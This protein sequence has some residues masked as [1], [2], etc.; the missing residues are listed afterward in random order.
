[1][2]Q[3]NNFNA[4]ILSEAFSQP[5]RLLIVDDDP[6]MRSCIRHKLGGFGLEIIERG[7]GCG[8]IEALET[9]EFDLVLLDIGLPDIS[10]LEVIEWISLN[11][12]QTSVIFV[13]A[14]DDIDS[15]ILA[16]RMGAVEYVRKTEDL[17]E[18][19]HKVSNALYRRRLEHKNSIMTA[20]LEHSEKLHRFLVE[21]SPDLI[22]TLDDNARFT[23]INK[24]FES[25]LGYSHDELIGSQY[26]TIVHEDDVEKALYAFSERRVDGRATSNLEVRLKCKNDGY[27]HFENNQIVSMLSATA[28]Y[29]D[30]HGDASLAQKQYLGTYGVAHNIT[31]RKIAEETIAYQAF[32]DQ[33]TVLPN[34]RLFKD[35]LEMAIIHARRSG[36]MVGVMFIDLDRFKLVN[37][38]Y[39]HAAGDELLKNVAFRLRLCMRA[40]DTL[41]R[42]G[43][44]EFTALLPDIMKSEDAT[45]VAEKIIC[46]LNVPFI[47]AGQ[48]M[49]IT[50]SIGIA[51]LPGDGEN[52]DTLLKN[53]DIAMY[54]VKEGGKNDFKYFIPSMNA[55][56]RERITLENDLRQAIRRNE[57]E[58]NYQPQFSVSK[59]TI[60]G[61]E[62]LIRW[63]HPTKGLL[64]PSSFIDLAEEIG[65]ISSITDWVLDAACKQLSLWRTGGFETLRMSVN[66]SPQEFERENIVARILPHVINYN[67][68][69]DSLEIEITENIMMRDAS[70]VIA[71]IRTLRSHGIRVVI[72]DFGTCYSSLNYLRLFPV[73]TIKID[74]SFVRDLFSEHSTVPIIQAITGIAHGYGLNLLAEGVESI[75]QSKALE[76]IGCDEMQGFYYSVPL[77][78]DETE[79]LLCSVSNGTSHLFPIPA[80]STNPVPAATSEFLQILPDNHSQLLLGRFRND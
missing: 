77:P 9:G 57:F 47:V 35:R 37:D 11:N 14:N 53:A 25:L 59:K 20:R 54:K 6:H 3:L 33:L 24:R 58:L 30:N 73:S 34:Q 70:S 51:V 22:Y 72:D 4:D 5:Q 43:G 67:L 40:G 71:K 26:S 45:I 36:N 50:A 66:V 80:H 65:L 2:I 42:N 68:P 16:L 76:E 79:R 41:A 7:S 28:I 60:V 46:E 78:S 29:T 75:E 21:N 1:V 19:K 64:N 61:V 23:F 55:S 12:I 17:P 62:A 39:G 27:C 44:D 18:I 38:T 15:A 48:D 56:N 31:E 8:A 32:H 69:A 52:V 63:N 74:Q 13:T 49:H 10:G